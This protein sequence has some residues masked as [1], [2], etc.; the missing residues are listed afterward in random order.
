M[1]RGAFLDIYPSEEG[2]QMKSNPE[3]GAGTGNSQPAPSA[4]VRGLL[5]PFAEGE[6]KRYIHVQS[7]T[8]VP[9]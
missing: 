2:S 8:L 3:G 6:V 4:V 5:A 7:G 9:S 1:A